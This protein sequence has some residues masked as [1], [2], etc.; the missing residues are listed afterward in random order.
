MSAVNTT[1]TTDVQSTSTLTVRIGR[2]IGNGDLAESV[3]S[4]LERISGINTVSVE[5]LSGVTPRG[6]AVYATAD[7]T[8]TATQDSTP[9][10]IEA[11]LQDAIAVESVE[12]L[13]VATASTTT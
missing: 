8:F 3:T 6:G 11:A 1:P 10:D 13:T 12:S 7:I 2:G 4:K 9:A 5:Q